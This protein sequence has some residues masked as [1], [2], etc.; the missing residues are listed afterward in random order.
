DYDNDGDLDLYL[1]NSGD[2][3]LLRNNAT[4]GANWVQFQLQ[5]TLSNRS[6]IGARVTLTAGGVTQV[7]EIS[8]GS[9]YGSQDAQT[10]SFGLGAV[11]TIDLVQIDWPSGVVQ[12][13]AP[14]PAVNQKIT[15]IEPVPDA[16]FTDVTDVALGVV[17]KCQGVAWGDYD[18]DGDPDLYITHSDIDNMLLENEGGTFIDATA[19][20]VNAPGSARGSAW[21]DYDNDGDLDLYHVKSGANQLF[22]NDGGSSFTDVSAGDIADAGVGISAAWADYDGDGDLDVYGASFTMN[23]ELFRND[24]GDTFTNV[25]TFPP[26]DTGAGTGIAWADYDGDGDP[27]FFLARSGSQTDKLYRNEG[28]GTF[29]DATSGSLGNTGAGRGVAWAD[30]DNDGDLDLYLANTNASNAL[31]RNDGGGTFVDVTSGPL[32]GSGVGGSVSWVDYDNDGDQDIYVGNS[33]Q[34]NQLFKNEGNGSFVSVTNALLGDTS[35]TVGLGWADYDLDGDLDLYL[36]NGDLNGLAQANKLLRN[37]TDAVSGNNWLQLKLSGTLSNRDAV[38]ALVSVTTG[39]TTQLRQVSAGSGC[40]SQDDLVVAFGLGTAASIDS[41]EIRWPSGVV[42]WVDGIA[43]NQKITVVETDPTGVD[44]IDTL[45][46]GFALYRASPNP[47]DDHTT[48]RFDVAR[49]EHV[50]LSVFDVSGRLVRVLENSVRSAGRHESVW[51]GRADGGERVAAG[52]YFY[53]LESASYHETRKLVR[54]R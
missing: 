20:P 31:Y 13:L 36:G 39:G 54:L 22:R 8:G 45:P 7:R 17:G 5:G 50:N 27:D 46:T 30:Y 10:A 52:V 35:Q 49:S 18:A 9:G 47:F 1:A 48:V 34:A 6:A 24:G 42:Q 3:K 38:G 37:D 32:A 14:S 19:A 43:V 2:N 11:A 12:T 29:V 15:V 40:W 16:L 25:G 41:I 21:A 4:A 23:S 44:P 33:G 53:R 26:N 28:G 51:D